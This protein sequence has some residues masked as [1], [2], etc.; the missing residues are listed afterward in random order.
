M[1]KQ[2]PEVAGYTTLPLQLPQTPAFSVQATHYLY[3]RPHEPRIPDPDSA[4]S[5]FLV[6]APID[7]TET[8]LRHLFGTQLSAGR[9]SSVQ[10]E[11]VPTK[12]QGVAAATES[13]LAHRPK[14]RKRATADDLQSKLDDISLPQTWDR[15][16]HKSGAHVIVV[17]AD[18]SS[19]EASM[20]AAA[21]AAKKGTKIVWGEGIPESKIPPLGTQRYLSHEHMRYPDRA[22]LLH[23]VNEFMTV[24]AE[25]SEARKREE[26]KKF[27]EPDDDGFITVT[28]G[29]KLNSTAR[30]DEVKELVERQKKKAAGL[31][32]FYRFQSREKRKERQNELLRK[33]GEDKKKLEEIKMRRGKIRPE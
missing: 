7:T 14:K 17:F 9:V 10:F 26:A 22:S 16:L 32:D 24:Y 33:F 6:N 20:K 25:V 30:E 29:P 23:T 27:A 4:R 5:L 21:K 19:M 12:K 8:H 13:N 3:I 31:E 28:H 18:R 1:K 15:Q 11:D 2:A